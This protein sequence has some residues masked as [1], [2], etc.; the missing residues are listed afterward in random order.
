MRLTDDVPELLNLQTF[1]NPS[2]LFG[3]FLVVGVLG[4]K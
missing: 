3:K 2:V 4:F 1:S